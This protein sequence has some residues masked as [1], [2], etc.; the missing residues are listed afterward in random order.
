MSEKV[1]LKNTELLHLYQKIKYVVAIVNKFS[2]K[3]KHYGFSIWREQARGSKR[4][5]NIL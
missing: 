2:R 3:D 4:I 5:K 1:L